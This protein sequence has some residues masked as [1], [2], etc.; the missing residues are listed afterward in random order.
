MDGGFP[1]AHRFEQQKRLGL[2]D[3]LLGI[4]LKEET[5]HRLR[6]ICHGMGKMHGRNNTVPS[7]KVKKMNY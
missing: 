3:S 1:L 4:L 6:F 7:N 5:K 2:N